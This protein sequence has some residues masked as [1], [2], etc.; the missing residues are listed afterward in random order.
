M[1]IFGLKEL[2]DVILMD[3]LLP[4]LLDIASL[5]QRTKTIQANAV[6][7]CRQA[8]TYNSICLFQYGHNKSD[9]VN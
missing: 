5:I 8:A 3:S 2:F 7:I 4:L 6:A 9:M 1:F